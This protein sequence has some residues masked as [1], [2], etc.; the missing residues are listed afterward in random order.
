M[1][2][3]EVQKIHAESGSSGGGGAA[4]EVRPSVL[5]T[6]ASYIITTEFCERLAYYGIT[7]FIM[8]NIGNC[9]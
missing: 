9:L 7:I 6:T 4:G 8:S 1:S 5:R 3:Q 2:A